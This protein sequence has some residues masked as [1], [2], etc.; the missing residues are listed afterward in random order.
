[1]QICA[2]RVPRAETT[3]LQLSWVTTYDLE[4]AASD[5]DL[6]IGEA[7]VVRAS[8]QVERFA[9]S[10]C[11]AHRATNRGRVASTPRSTAFRFR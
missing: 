10:S 7:H 1:M 11:S 6:R 9:R 3:S 2:L 4:D 8:L 5:I